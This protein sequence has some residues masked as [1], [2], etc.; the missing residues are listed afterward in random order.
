[1]FA[2]KYTALQYIEMQSS[3]ICL[4]RNTGKYAMYYNLLHRT[5]LYFTIPLQLFFDA[6]HARTLEYLQKQTWKIAHL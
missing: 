1:M 3:E 6:L 4:N 2:L 5:T